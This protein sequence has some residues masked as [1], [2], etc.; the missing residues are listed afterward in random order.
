VNE[1]AA[2]PAR[3]RRLAWASTAGVALLVLAAVALLAASEHWPVARELVLCRG[4]GW[5]ALAALL[6]S[7]M[8]FGRV[9]ARFGHDRSALLPVARRALGMASAWLALIHAALA[10]TTALR[11]NWAALLSWPHLR[12]GLTALGA[13]TVLLV[14]SFGAVVTRLRLRTWKELHRLSYVAALLALQ[15]VLLSPFAPRTL[16]L[17][18]FGSL[19]ALGGLRFLSRTGPPR[20]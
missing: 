3:L 5:L 14:T 1:A 13:L 11:W 12:A 10:L 4:T 16:T 20:V 7:L 15:H 18:L 9:A 2:A 6:L 8:P 19:L 17:A